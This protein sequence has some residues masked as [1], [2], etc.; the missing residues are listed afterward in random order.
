ML[1]LDKMRHSNLYNSMIDGEAVKKLTEEFH[2]KGHLGDQDFFT[3][4]SMK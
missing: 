2:F 1:D 3:L 4:L